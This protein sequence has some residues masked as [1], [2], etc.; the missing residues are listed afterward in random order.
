MIPSAIEDI[1]K[2]IEDAIDKFD[3]ISRNTAPLTKLN[4]EEN[5]ETPQNKAYIFEQLQDYITSFETLILPILNL[6][7]SISNIFPSNLATKY[8]KILSDIIDWYNELLDFNNE[9]KKD[10][11]GFAIQVTN[12]VEDIEHHVEDST[13]LL[14]KFVKL[15]TDAQLQDEDFV[16]H[17]TGI[18]TTLYDKEI[19][20]EVKEY[21]QFL[22]KQ[23]TCTSL[24]QWLNDKQTLIDT[25]KN[26]AKTALWCSLYTDDTDE[27]KQATI[28]A[29]EILSTLWLIQTQ[30]YE[31][32]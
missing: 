25:T 6:T 20:T 15:F 7:R 23:T 10:E 28:F 24:Y 1:V 12:Y 31:T 11:L 19:V 32:I 3:R 27:Q 30:K 14:T 16:D 17:I 18:Y 29:Q 2:P 8:T 4:K 9:E 5:W 22:Q 13:K 26:L 21:Q